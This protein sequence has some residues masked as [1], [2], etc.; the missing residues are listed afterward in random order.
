MD[1]ISLMPAFTDP[2]ASPGAKS[3]AFSEF[4]QCPSDPEVSLWHT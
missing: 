1:G 4:P 2:S 3:Y